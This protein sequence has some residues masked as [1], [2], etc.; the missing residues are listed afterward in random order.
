MDYVILGSVLTYDVNRGFVSK[1]VFERRT[2][3]GSD[4]TILKNFTSLVFRQLI[5][6]LFFVCS[7][8]S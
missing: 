3:T 7:V 6:F 5:L 4:A 2:S 8:Y 1:D